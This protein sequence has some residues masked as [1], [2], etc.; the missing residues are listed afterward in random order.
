VIRNAKMFAMLLFFFAAAPCVHGQFGEEDET[1]PTG[2]PGDSLVAAEVLR[3]CL[4]PTNVQSCAGKFQGGGTSGSCSGAVCTQSSSCN[5]SNVIRYNPK[6]DE[7]TGWEYRSAYV[8]ENGFKL[9]PKA[10]NC[11]VEQPCGCVWSN[12]AQD[13]TCQLTTG[14]TVLQSYQKAIGPS[15]GS[16][17]GMAPH[18]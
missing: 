16:C 14:W 18:P 13:Y 1:P 5:P 7:P 9:K 10:V 12:E 3:D 8:G 2:D 17:E 11:K 4:L 15:T 6:W